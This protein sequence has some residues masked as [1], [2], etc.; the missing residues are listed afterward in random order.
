MA[1]GSAHISSSAHSAQSDGLTRRKVS[2][3]HTVDSDSAEDGNVVIMGGIT[4]SPESTDVQSAWAIRYQI[5]GESEED[6]EAESYG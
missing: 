3:E 5:E 6:N 2:G 1:F 4:P